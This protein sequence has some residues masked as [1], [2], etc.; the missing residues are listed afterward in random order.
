M[1]FNMKN[2]EVQHTLGL[3]RGPIMW[4]RVRTLFDQGWG[5]QHDMSTKTSSPSQCPS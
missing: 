1:F 4:T 2:S 5:V 3:S